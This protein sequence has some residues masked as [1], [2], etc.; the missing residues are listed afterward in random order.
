[1]T[2]EDEDDSKLSWM[3]WFEKKGILFQA[4][5]YPGYTL[6]NLPSSPALERP[7]YG[8]FSVALGRFGGSANR[9]D[10]AL[11]TP[12]GPDDSGTLTGKVFL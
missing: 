9:W 8:S 5:N 6:L 7:S 11:G 12:R 2:T 1:M 4:E 10:V 3:E